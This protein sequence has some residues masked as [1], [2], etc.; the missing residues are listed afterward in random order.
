M[1]REENFMG[2]KNHRILDRGKGKHNQGVIFLK[3]RESGK[4]NTGSG[5]S[6][7][8]GSNGMQPDRSGNYIGI[9]YR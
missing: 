6:V 4:G 2:L 1:H 7:R 3:I 8:L 5:V 9:Q